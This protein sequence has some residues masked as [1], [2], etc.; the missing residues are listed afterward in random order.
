MT[1][2]PSRAVLFEMLKS[3]TTLGKTLNLS[4]ATELLGTT[5]QTVRRHIDALEEIKGVK[6]FELKHRQYS[7]TSEGVRNM[8]DAEALLRRAE[9]WLDGSMETTG[10]LSRVMVKEKS[11]FMTYMQQHPIY[12]IWEDSPPLLGRSL[13]AWAGAKGRIEDSAM[14]E[15]RPYLVVYRKQLESWITVSIGEQSAIAR[16]LGWVWAKST[17]GCPLEADPLSSTADPFTAEAYESIV[18]TGGIRLDHVHTMIQR[19]GDGPLEPVNYH[20]LLLCG[21]FPNGQT[22]TISMAAITN[23][24]EIESLDLDQIPQAQEDDLMEFDLRS[25]DE[26]PRLNR[27]EDSACVEGERCSI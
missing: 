24:I 14:E 21:I 7:L 8:E 16:W 2:H 4:H 10:G 23:K 15:I 6:L 18:Q 27:F 25:P 3:F 19:K 26:N 9:A 20:R 22:A 17:V 1:E 13:V 11:G 5:R 12:R